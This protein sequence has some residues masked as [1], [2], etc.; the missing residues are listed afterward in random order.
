MN[1]PAPTAPVNSSGEVEDPSKIPPAPKVNPD[2]ERVE[3]Q[4][5]TDL[6]VKP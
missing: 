3:D 4:S 2:S 1:D 5:P 6:G